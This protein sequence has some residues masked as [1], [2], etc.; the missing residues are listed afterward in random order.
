MAAVMMVDVVV[1]VCIKKPQRDARAVPLDQ[2][3]REGPQST[4]K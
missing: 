3:M 1:V 4:Y 2:T